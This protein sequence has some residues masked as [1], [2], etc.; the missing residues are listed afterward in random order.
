M[1]DQA[2]EV[3]N[4]SFSRITF[5]LSLAIIVIN[6]FFDNPTKIEIDETIS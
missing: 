1:F 5:R 3:Y 2:A 6:C 4:I